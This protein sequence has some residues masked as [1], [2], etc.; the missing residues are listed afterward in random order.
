MDELDD[1]SAS[2]AQARSQQE[3]HFLLSANDTRQPMTSIIRAV[4]QPMKST[5]P[6][7]TAALELTTRRLAARVS[8]LENRQTAMD[9][10]QALLCAKSTALRKCMARLCEAE[11][12]RQLA[13]R[14]YQLTLHRRAT[15]AGDT[16]TR[17]QTEGST[18]DHVV[19]C[20]TSGHSA[21]PVL[22]QSNVET[23]VMVSEPWFSD[24]ATGLEHWS[25]ARKEGCS[26]EGGDVVNGRTSNDLLCKVMQQNAR[27]KQTIKQLIDRHGLT[28]SEYLVSVLSKSGA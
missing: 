6:V 21:V 16:A 7:A 25:H 11:T 18:A 4:E 9:N 28:V 13:E 10:L 23:A 22:G 20:G 5:S 24:V 14:R 1:V 19:D 15:S 17:S 27:L 3:N 26:Q 12:A 8:S 2:T